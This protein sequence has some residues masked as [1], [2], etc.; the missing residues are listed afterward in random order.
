MSR[1]TKKYTCVGEVKPKTKA[2]GHLKVKT[3]LKIDGKLS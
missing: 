1:A 3:D 2:L